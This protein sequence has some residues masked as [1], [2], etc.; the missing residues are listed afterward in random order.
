[1]TEKKTESLDTLL[2]Q[3][4]TEKPKRKSQIHEY[5]LKHKTPEEIAEWRKQAAEKRK[6]IWA[7][8]K[9]EKEAM[10]EKAKALMPE[11]LAYDLLSEE[12]E[13]ENWI[14]KQDLIDK[15]KLIL[16]KDIPLEELRARYFKNVSD[17]TWHHLMKFVFKSQISQSEDLG[18]EIMRVKRASVDRLRKQLRDIKKQM[19]YHKEETGKKVVPAYLLNMKLDIENR[20]M[21]LEQDVAKT[22]FQIGAVGEKSKAPSFIV[23]MKLPRP[24]KKEKDIVEVN[25]N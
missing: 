19:K 24:E 12:V 21:D 1:M 8:K 22:L 4:N 13:K 7:Q 23:N 20:L 11:M 16:K 15:V 6:A 9:A 14:P 18:A 5:F 10:M 17:K 25:G 3:H 2:Q